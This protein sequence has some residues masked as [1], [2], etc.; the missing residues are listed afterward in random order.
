MT[1]RSW[2]DASPGSDAYFRIRRSPGCITS[3]FGGV[4]PLR[5]IASMTR[6]ALRLA[7]AFYFSLCFTDVMYVS[8]L[9]LFYMMSRTGRLFHHAA[10]SL[11]VLVAMG[12]AGG[13]ALLC[14]LLCAGRHPKRSMRS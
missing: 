8:Y 10:M 12:A 2:N 13:R 4:H 6:R 11:F 1:A 7:N 14:C 3:A 9:N 5:E